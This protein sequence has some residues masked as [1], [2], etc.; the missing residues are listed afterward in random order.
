MASD[1]PYRRGMSWEAARAE[2]LRHRDTQWP[3]RVVDAF[4]AMMEE[5]QTEGAPSGRIARG[6]A[7]G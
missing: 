3:S 6:V 5:A 4:V 1:R 2:L 7:T